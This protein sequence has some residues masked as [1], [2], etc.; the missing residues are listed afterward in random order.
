MSAQDAEKLPELVDEQRVIL[1]AARRFVVD[2]RGRAQRPRV[3]A[4]GPLPNVIA[5]C[6]RRGTGKTTILEHLRRS[7]TCSPHVLCTGVLDAATIERD[8]GIMA[9]V[10][11]CAYDKRPADLGAKERADLERE[12][13]RCL[14]SALSLEEPHRALAREMAMSSAHYEQS[15]MKATL[16]RRE[17]PDHWK[18]FIGALAASL[19]RPEGDG[20]ASKHVVVLLDDLDLCPATDT[21]ERWVVSMVNRTHGGDCELA[22]VTWVVSFD[23][24]RL[25]KRLSPPSSHD[26]RPGRDDPRPAALDEVV[27]QALLSK[28][29]PFDRQHQL[30]PWPFERR[31]AFRGGGRT[32]TVGELLSRTGRPELLPSLPSHPRGLE[33]IHA[34]LGRTL[35]GGA[36]V[37][38]QE[39]VQ[40]LATLRGEPELASLLDMGPARWVNLL[41]WEEEATLGSAAWPTLVKAARADEPLWG[42]PIPRALSPHIRGSEPEGIL[43]AL[44]D[45]ALARGHLTPYQLLRR[46]PFASSRLDEASVRFTFIEAETIHYMERRSRHVTPAFEWQEWAG[47]ATAGGLWAVTIGPQSLWAAQG[48]LRRPEPTELLRSLYLPQPAPRPLE[49]GVIP[50]PC[51]FRA[52]VLLVD[53]LASMPWKELSSVRRIWSPLAATRGVAMLTLQAY[54]AAAGTK[55]AREDFTALDEDGVAAHYGE[56]LDSLDAPRPTTR[57]RRARRPPSEQTEPLTVTGVARARMREALTNLLGRDGVQGLRP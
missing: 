12:H 14:E 4:V 8:L 23:R 20:L 18:S 57:T 56:L 10:I 21:L 26:A 22:A 15:V 13:R 3:P 41:E 54:S 34:W 1:H 30:R 53:A 25:I 49:R 7:L 17:S 45:L 40:R 44:V 19:P 46:M 2:E 24:E 9:A 42:I 33:G 51:S 11:Q 37:E 55:P 5:V 50:L 43:E 32:E 16:K 36:A 28:L 29:V 27:G 47:E 38:P 6:G 52:L 48:G 35:D 31:G 39:L